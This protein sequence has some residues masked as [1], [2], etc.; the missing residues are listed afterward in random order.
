MSA[1]TRPRGDLIAASTSP[2]P[3][4]SWMKSIVRLSGPGFTRVCGR[5]RWTDKGGEAGSRA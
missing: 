4:A 2:P 5:V 3:Q 1:P